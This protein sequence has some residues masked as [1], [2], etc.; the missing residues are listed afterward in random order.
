MIIYINKD[1]YLAAPG[2]KDC[3]IEYE[4]TA[5]QATM[6]SSFPMDKRWKLINGKLTLVDYITIADIRNLRD[7][8]CFSVINRG[9]LWYELLTEQQKVELKKWYNAWLDATDTM[10]IPKKPS[11]L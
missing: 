7:N 1:G 6:V 2:V 5:D 10:V 8:E 9:I 3:N 4:I 11:W